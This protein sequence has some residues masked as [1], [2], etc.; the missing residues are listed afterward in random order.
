MVWMYPP[1]FPSR[2]WKCYKKDPLG[3]PRGFL[4]GFCS[5]QMSKTA[6]SAG[7]TPEIRLA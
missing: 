5:S 6:T 3:F 2:Y 1:M 4:Y 7:L